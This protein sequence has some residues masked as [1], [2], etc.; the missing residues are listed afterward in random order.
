MP[1]KTP[2]AKHNK[3]FNSTD[4]LAVQDTFKCTVVA[5]KP[6]SLFM[7]CHSIPYFNQ[8]GATCS[9]FHTIKSLDLRLLKK[10]NTHTHTG[11]GSFCNHL[12]L[13]FGCA[14]KDIRAGQDLQFFCP[15]LMLEE[16]DMFPVFLPP[17]KSSRF[18]SNFG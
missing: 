3:G 4:A 10:T 7:M 18:H 15:L 5:L 13:F 11:T 6:V 1:K 12:L 8:N 17:Q 9:Y 16:F 14:M 2:R